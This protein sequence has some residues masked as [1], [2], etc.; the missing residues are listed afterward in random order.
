[1]DKHL[2]IFVF[3]SWHTTPGIILDKDHRS[4][5]SFPLDP[6]GIQY[7]NHVHAFGF[8]V[9]ALEYLCPNMS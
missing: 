4:G 3:T 5:V 8:L 7:L 2:L 9:R 1:M 6:A